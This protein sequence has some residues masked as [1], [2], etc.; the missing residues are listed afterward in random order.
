MT[1]QEVVGG[2]TASFDE[3]LNDID[4][5]RIIDE[6]LPLADATER[7]MVE[8]SLPALDGSFIKA[9]LPTSS[10]IW[11]ED[12][13]QEHKYQ[14]GRDWWYYR[15]PSN[16]DHVEDIDAWPKQAAENGI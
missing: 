8:A 9:T 10:C 6:L 1:V 2:Y 12:V 11:G 5:R 13:A 16:L 3:Y 15:I 4:G 14:P 7:A